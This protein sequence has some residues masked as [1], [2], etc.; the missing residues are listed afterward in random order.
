[1]KIGFLVNRRKP[2]AAEFVPK[3]VQ[4]LKSKGHKPF[5][6]AST[7]NA[8]NL[9]TDCCPAAQ[10][11]SRVDLVVAL[12][13]DGTMLRAARLVGAN[14]IPIMGV[15]LGGLG[16]LTEFS[17]KETRRGIEAFIHGKHAEEQRMVICCRYGTKKGFALND[18]AINMGAAGRVIEVIGRMSGSFMNKFVGDGVV[19][20]TPTGST[21]YSLAAGGPVVY[22]TMEALLLTPIAPHALAARPLILPA[23]AELELE[24]GPTSEP[25]FLNLDGQKRWQLAPGKPI[26][27]SRA[28]FSIRIV[29]PKGKTYYRILRDKMKWSGSQS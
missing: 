22:P 18:C 8:F 5:L 24:L 14:N 7:A 26:R 25:A 15:N 9:K 19:V 16:F 1:V 23:D 11:V 10:L 20:A 29:T 17:L 28:P 13:G 6:A 27:I 3:I 12:G 21:A 4:W 2:Q